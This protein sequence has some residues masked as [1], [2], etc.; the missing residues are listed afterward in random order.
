M[1]VC[2]RTQEAEAGVQGQPVLQSEFKDSQGYIEKPSLGRGKGGLKKEI[3][4]S[5]GP[6]DPLA[7]ASLALV[8]QAYTTVHDFLHGC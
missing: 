7:P 5:L 6:R 8:L 3:S 2:P 1:L 4:L